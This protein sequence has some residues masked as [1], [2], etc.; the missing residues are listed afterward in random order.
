MRIFKFILLLL[1]A[2]CGYQFQGSGTSLPDDIKTI[3]V[4]VVENETTEPAI[5]LELTEK[6][7]S[8]VERYG[9]VRLVKDERQADVVLRTKIADIST[10]VQ[11]VAG[12]TDIEL[13]QEILMLLRAELRRKNGQILYKNNQ[14]LVRDTFAS[15]SDVVVTSSSSFSQSGLSAGNIGALGNR[16][17]SRGQKRIAIEQLLDDASRIIYEDSIASDF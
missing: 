1:L 14:L 15:T 17:V 12:E 2:S 9:V 6:L 11:D 4:P 3:A 8:R 16:E 13:E 10:R 5:G 7:R